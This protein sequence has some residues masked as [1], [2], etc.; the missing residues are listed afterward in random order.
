MLFI[1]VLTCVLH[2]YIALELFEIE[3]FH[4]DHPFLPSHIVGLTLEGSSVD[5]YGLLSVSR[6]ASPAEIK[7]AYHRAL[8]ISHPDKQTRQTSAPF[9]ITLI[10]EAYATLAD[11]NTRSKYDLRPQERSSPQGPRPAQVVSLEDFNENTEGTV[12]R[13]DCRCSGFYEISESDLER[14]KHIV[15]CGSC[16]EVVWVG[17][18]LA[19]DDADGL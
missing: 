15:G 13:Y 18:K 2:T 19:Q 8:L 3:I 17:Y 12:W 6:D 7:A 5:Y 4:S 1:F 10:K 16:S 11:P 9:D 14:G